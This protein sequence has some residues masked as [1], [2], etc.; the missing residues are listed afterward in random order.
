MMSECLSKCTAQVLTPHN[1]FVDASLHHG[2][3]GTHS[4]DTLRGM[5]SD[6]ALPSSF[7]YRVHAIRSTSMGRR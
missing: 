7:P 5:R 2:S 3:D 1:H 6:S 4:E